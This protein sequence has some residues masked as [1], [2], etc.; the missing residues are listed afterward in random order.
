MHYGYMGWGQFLTVSLPFSIICVLSVWGFLWLFF[1]PT[2]E[3][4]DALPPRHLEPFSVQHL[5]IIIVC[6][7]TIIL[8][9]LDT[10]VAGYVRQYII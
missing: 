2:L 4:V 7:S 3:S 6:L 1:R 10:R 5:Y 9:A 8:W